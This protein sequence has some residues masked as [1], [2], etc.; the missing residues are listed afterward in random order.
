L[1]KYEITKA[2]AGI[3]LS[4]HVFEKHQERT[5]REWEQIRTTLEI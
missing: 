2:T 1:G 3:M 4:T 5:N